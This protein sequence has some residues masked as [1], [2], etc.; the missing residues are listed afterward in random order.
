MQHYEPTQLSEG[1][2]G[3]FVFFH[4]DGYDLC[5]RINGKLIAYCNTSPLRMLAWTS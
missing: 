1:D 5:N 2:F 4:M 3:L